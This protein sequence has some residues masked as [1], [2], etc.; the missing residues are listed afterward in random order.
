[1]ERCAKERVNMVTLATG[2]G[3][4]AMLAGYRAAYD[5]APEDMPL[6]GVGRHVVVADT[7]AEAEAIA[8]PAFARWRASFV[9]LWETRGGSNPFVASFPADWDAFVA[10]GGGVAGSPATVCG[11]IEREQALGGF[12]YFMAQMAFGGMTVAEVCRSAELMGRE[13]I[14]AFA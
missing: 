11:F 6:L 14:P 1:V 7:D 3:M 10:N 5:G 12:T 4:R 2:E 9:H 13:V 8:R